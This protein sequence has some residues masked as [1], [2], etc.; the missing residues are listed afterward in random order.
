MSA[1]PNSPPRKVATRERL[2]FALD[3]PDL[4]GA[5]ALVTKLDD[6]VWFYRCIR[7]RSGRYRL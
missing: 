6:S 4:A 3:V 5:K 2:I 1:K 7:D